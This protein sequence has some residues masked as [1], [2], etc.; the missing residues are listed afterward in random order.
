M[1]R[2]I[3]RTRH[4]LIDVPPIAPE[5]YADTPAYDLLEAAARGWLAIDHRFLHAIL[6]DPGR[7]I[8]DVVRFATED[9][10]DRIGLSEDLM[11]IFAVHPV[12]E[13][14]PF[15]ISEIEAFPEDIPEFL[16]APAFARIGEP[17]IEA[18]IETGEPA[19]EIGF[20]LASLGIRDPRIFRFLVDYLERDL[21]DGAFLCEVY[22][23]P[24]LAPHL[25]AIRD[26]APDEAAEALKALG[27]RARGEWEPYD[28]WR[29]Y[30]AADQPDVNALPAHERMLFLNSPSAELRLAGVQGWRGEDLPSA[31]VARIL[32]IA[33]TDGDDRVRGAAWEALRDEFL[34]S[35][36]AN[37][38]R[39]RLSSEDLGPHER[40]GI[41]LAM[42]IHVDPASIEQIILAS[43][44]WGPTRVKALEAMWRSRSQRFAE[45]V[46]RHLD[47]ADPDLVREAICGVGALELRGEL[48]R[49]EAFI[50]NPEFRDEALLNY[51]LAAPASNTRSGM[52][53]LVARLKTLA[54]EFSDEDET[55]VNAAVGLRMDSYGMPVSSEAP[56]AAKSV[57]VG[58]NEP[59]PCG[60]GK[61][62]KKCCGA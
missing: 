51:V 28:I 6:D 44:E 31:V 61:K 1:L 29:D 22:N 17:A 20:L 56:A 19:G 49:L 18:L 48:G 58:R 35:P 11:R 14:L 57:K 24:A 50:H 34:E 21:E 45:Y 25:E 62:Y 15:L 59:C 47:D 9:R 5:Q 41:A 7:T 2:R 40:V 30:P 54:G 36:I 26:R 52:M 46:V 8:G 43:Y 16:L 10:D 33:R 23:D 37:A 13:A 39:E 12:P 27:T 60:S 53:Q 3:R 4:V 55:I 32:D 38:M 42:S